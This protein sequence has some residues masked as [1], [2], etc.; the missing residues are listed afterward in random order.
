MICIFSVS[1]STCPEE[2]LLQEMKP[3]LRFRA[4]TWIHHFTEKKVVRKPIKSDSTKHYRPSIHYYVMSLSVAAY[5]FPWG[6]GVLLLE[7]IPA[8]SQGEGA[9]WT[10][11]QLIA[12][13]SLM[14]IV[15]F[16]ISLKHTSTCSSALPGAGI[17]T[18]D[19]SIASR[20]AL[21]TELQPP[22]HYYHYWYYYY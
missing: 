14:S 20:P 9:P 2:N 6:R 18:S 1:Y 15:G 12:G 11:R 21:P 10:S 13:P 5:P 7:P 22:L 17:W 19:L 8:L 3:E 16:S 4:E